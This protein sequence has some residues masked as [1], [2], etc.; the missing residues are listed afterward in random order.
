MIKT[1]L[2]LVATLAVAGACAKPRFVTG[3]E[4]VASLPRFQ[5]KAD[6]MKAAILGAKSDFS[7]ATGIRYYVSA[8]GLDTNDGRSDAR[9]IRSLDAV[10]RLQLKPGDAVLFRRGDLFRGRMRARPGVT[11]SA[12]GAGP[13]PTVCASVRNYADASIWEPTDVTNVWRC[14]VPVMNAGVI[15]FDHDPCCVGRYDVKFGRLRHSRG[16]VKSPA[17]LTNDLDFWSDLPNQRLCLCSEKGNPGMVFKRIEIGC[18]DHAIAIGTADNVTIDNLHVTLTGCH[19]V[20]AGTVRNLEVRNCVFDWLGGSLLVPEG[21]KGGPCR[22]GNAVEVYGGCD[23]YRVH[24]CWMY[25]IYDTGITHQCH[26]ANGSEIR[27]FN[28]EHARNLIEYCFWSIEYYNA[29]NKFGETRNV[30]VHDNF[31]RFGGYGWGCLGRAEGAPMYSIDDRPD[32]TSNYVNE[33]NVLERCLGILVNNFGRH[34]AP[35]DFVFRKNVYVQPRGWHFASI[36]DR[37]PR[38]SKFDE[39]AADVIRETFGEEDGEFYFLPEE[40]KVFPK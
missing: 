11:Y 35:P 17:Q 1:C 7:A 27:Q 26:H 22:F 16:G 14:T 31:C 36:G 8:E 33:A 39:S 19:G 6:A 20:G 30:Y 37:Q 23:G 32:V 29:F 28:V 2:A 38:L 21:R 15:T 12:Y 10:A 40:T 5:A 25:Q 9:A 24:D 4:A 3:Q 18:Q 34:A 13:K